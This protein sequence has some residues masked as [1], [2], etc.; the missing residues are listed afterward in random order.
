[1]VDV[2]K[3]D[4]I[5]VA[6]SGEGHEPRH[7]GS[8]VV[9]PFDQAV[10][11]LAVGVDS[12]DHD[13][14]LLVDERLGLVSRFGSALYRESE[15]FSGVVHPERNVFDAVSM[16]VDVSRDFAVGSQCGG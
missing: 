1:M 10:N 6:A 8:L 5:C 16:F 7:E 13:L 9:L 15:C 3:T 12:R 14:A 11:R 4:A 2:V